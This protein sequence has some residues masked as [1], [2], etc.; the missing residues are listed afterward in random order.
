MAVTLNAKGT[1]VSSFTIGKGGQAITLNANGYLT[2]DDGVD[3]EQ[4]LGYN[5]IPIY[6]I[7]AN[8]TFDLAH[9]GMMWH[10]DAG[11]AVTFTCD[12]DSTIPQGSTWIVHNDDAED[13]TIAE[14]TGVTIA[15]LASGAAPTTGNVTVSQGGIIT[16][17]KYTDTE[18]WV[19]GDDGPFN[20]LTAGSTTDATLRWNGSAWAENTT[21]TATSTGVLTAASTAG[22]HTFSVDSATTNADIPV[23]KLSASS[24]GTPA[25][26]IGPSIQF[27]AET[28]ASNL[29]IGGE[30]ALEATDVTATT[31]DFDFVFN[32][33]AAGAAAAE[34]F[35]I[36]SGGS[37]FTTDLSLTGTT[38]LTLP[39]T[40]DAVTPTLTFGDADSGFY[41]SAD[42]VI[43]VALLGTARMF[44]DGAGG[45]QGFN[46]ATGGS[47]G[48]RS[49]VVASGTAPSILP[50]NNDEDTGLGA[51]AADQLS[52]VAGAKEMLRLSET[53]TATTDQIIISPSGIIGTGATPALAFGDGDTGFYENIDDQLFVSILGT[54]RWQFVGNT[55]QA[56][57]TNGPYLENS[58]PSSTN[59]TLAP[60]KSD[61]NTGIGWNSADQLSLI[62]GAVE[63][64]RFVNDTED[65][66]LANTPIL[67]AQSSAAV[68]DVTNYGQIWIKDDAATTLMFTDD[69]GVDQVVITDD[70]IVGDLKNCASGT[71]TLSTT[72]DNYV[73]LF[74]VSRSNGAHSFVLHTVMSDSGFSVAK[75]YLVTAGYNGTGGTTVYEVMIPDSDSGVYSG[76]DYRVEIDVTT[77]VATVRAVRTSGA[78]GSTLDWEIWAADDSS[79]AL[80]ITP[81]SGTGTSAVTA[82]YNP[83]RIADIKGTDYLDI[84]HDGTDINFAGTN[85]TDINMTSGITA[86]NLPEIT[87]TTALDETYGG[88][89]QTTYTTGDILYASGSNV[90]S[91]LPIGSAGTFLRSNSSTVEWSG[92]SFANSATTGDLIYASSA[93]N[94][95]NLAL[96]NVGEVLTVVGSNVA[97]NPPAVI[98]FAYDSTTTAA[99]PGAGTIRFNSVTI[100]SITTAYID[101]LDASGDNAEWILSN[102]ADGDILTF[103]SITDSADYIIASVNGSTTDGTG[104]W[105][106]PLTLIHTGTIFTNGDQMRVSVEWAGSNASVSGFISGTVANDQIVV[107]TGASSVDSSANLTYNGT[108]LT[109]A[110]AGAQLLLPQEND[111]ATPTL[112]FGDGDTGFYEL[113]DDTLRLSIGTSAL[114]QFDATHITG[115]TSASFYLRNTTVTDVN[116]SIGPR[117]DTNTG[118][119]SAAND[120]M[121]LIAGGTEHMRFDATVGG[122]DHIKA[123]VPIYMDERVAA[124]NDYANY[125]QLWVRTET[126][127]MLMFTD[128]AGN[129]FTANNVFEIAYAYSSAVTSTDP[130]AGTL[131]FNSVTIGSITTVYIDDLD[132]TGRDNSYMLST[133]ADGDLIEFRSA[134]D[135]AD[136]IVATVNGAPTDSTG[137]WT[138]SLTLVNTGTIFTNG[139]Q[140]RIIPTFL[141]QAPGLQNIVEDTSPQLGASL[142]TND[143]DINWKDGNF[144]TF[145]TGSDI[146]L[147][148]DNTDFEVRAAV[149]SSVWNFRDGLHIKLWDDADTN[150]LQIDHDGTDVNFTHPDG[151]TTSWNISGITDIAAGTV[152]ADFDAI[153]ATSY[154]GI[155]E[156]N[157]V[158][159]TANELISGDWVFEADT[160]VTEVRIR[161]TA[162]ASS[163][164]ISWENELDVE[165]WRISTSA[166]TDDDFF[167]ARYNDSA[168]FQDAPLFIDGLTGEVQ[169]RDGVGLRISDSLDT[170]YVTINHDADDLNITGTGAVDINITGY[171]A[172]QAGTVDAD[173]DA[174]TAT[175]YGGITEANLLDKTAAETISGVYTHSAG[176][177]I[178]DTTEA[179]ALRAGDTSAVFAGDQIT[180]GFDGNNQYQHAIG[181]RHNSAADANNA[182][183][184]YL[185]D[186]GTDTTNVVGTFRALTLDQTGSSFFTD[187]DISGALTLG[188]ALDEAE[189]G[190]G[191]T[192]YATGDILYAS[193][194]NTLAKL[195]AGTNTH[196]LTLSG[197]VPTWAAAPGATPPTTITVA[198]E[199]TDTTCFPLFVTAATGDLGPKTNANLTFNSNTGHFTATSKSF[200]IKH[201]TKPGKKLQ[202][203]SLEGPEHGVYVRG[204]LTDNDTI[205]LPDYW[206]ALIDPNSITVNLTPVGAHQELYVADIGDNKVIVGGS[207]DHMDF[208]YTVYAERVDVDRIE[209]EIDD[210]DV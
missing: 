18:Y 189:G 158:D 105:T 16:V 3:T 43:G 83:H 53:G 152:D 174:I 88:T 27:E 5:T 84:T 193:G 185:W 195:A 179:L 190:T 128:D 115:T 79:A 149:G 94:Y 65:Y 130:G 161:K 23:V 57:A 30:I 82:I 196:V 48:L 38:H 91:K 62:A 93:N 164:Y 150:S 133:L 121:S 1:S 184:F 6:E 203:G 10:K 198:N 175:S 59:P 147:Q 144:A 55:F 7:D 51:A 11:G 197:G 102:L 200:L 34:R 54:A 17:Y 21:I 97:W 92:V 186:F 165:R 122:Q 74:S 153:T 188:T 132:D 25:A 140:L 160:G 35:R 45:S 108:T 202:Y 138:I 32:T 95:D 117:R 68:A 110:G 118:I 209:L 8:D 40:N 137:F 22:N 80:T 167:I 135:P 13:I 120:S 75:T 63:M 207:T 26:G 168:V 114:Y 87:L 112:A 191:Q 116:P 14:G 204:R 178:T 206:T 90:L 146:W 177:V 141:S 52:L 73:E 173:F 101:D 199:A 24:T 129:D 181:T 107:G 37:S 67:I 9:A 124:L 210:E 125:G 31:E 143:F 99:D 131:N 182:I 81:L 156:A 2:I 154:G 136:Y 172:I 169:I 15:F 19:W 192:T 77:Q 42:D 12:N 47:F 159:K 78:N 39:S 41:E 148:W 71:A 36:S 46:S 103:R 49:Q 104:Y 176:I 119:G 163:S 180:F 155:T 126:P 98:Q 123:E 106:V 162:A 187:L 166:D 76:N 85:T 72:A 20:I 56:N 60:N 89:G 111:A 64:A 29:E 50:N 170:S 113:S 142:D 69:T 171:T 96:G 61:V 139:D 194:A 4:P 127:N 100:G 201:P 157:L 145:G 33:M 183:D 205:E 134:S 58:T 109:M 66:I 208:F 86:V 151:T 44:F 70:N 28:A